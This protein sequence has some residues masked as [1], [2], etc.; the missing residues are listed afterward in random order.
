MTPEKQG[1][2]YITEWDRAREVQP[3]PAGLSRL[4]EAG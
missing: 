2:P 4:S 3:F 1:I